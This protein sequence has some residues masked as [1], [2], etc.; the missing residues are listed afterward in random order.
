MNV[1]VRLT[2]DELEY[3][4]A[5]PIRIGL[6]DAWRVCQNV[7][8]E[9]ANRFNGVCPDKLK[10]L[11][12]KTETRFFIFIAESDFT[13]SRRV[14]TRRG[15][16]L[17]YELMQSRHKDNEFV[18]IVPHFARIEKRILYHTEHFGS[19]E[20]FLD[21]IDNTYQTQQKG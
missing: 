8:K 14:A 9:L 12:G 17:Q 11:I 19:L 7:A 1:I 13:P 16:E 15:I 6:V 21:Y 18:F 3:F 20:Q 2:D 5:I 10:D 4:G